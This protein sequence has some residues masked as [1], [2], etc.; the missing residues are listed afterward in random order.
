M[1]I[2][3][4]TADICKWYWQNSK[5]LA[6]YVVSGTLC[7]DSLARSATVINRM[8]FYHYD[9]IYAEYIGRGFEPYYAEIHRLF[10][11][12]DLTRRT[13]YV[14]EV[15]ARVKRPGDNRHFWIKAEGLPRNILQGPKPMILN[16]RVTPGNTIRIKSG[17]E[18]NTIWLSPD[19]V[20]FDERVGVFLGNRRKFNDFLRLDVEAMLEDLRIRGDR[21]K[22]YWVK[23]EL[24]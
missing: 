11:W 2:A 23:M 5:Y 8:M 7:R 17:A 14:K 18:R 10:D 6:W 19:F 24:D 3:A 4:V 20:D 13:K 9:V 15:D 22:L 12:M 16:A 1:P 21:Q